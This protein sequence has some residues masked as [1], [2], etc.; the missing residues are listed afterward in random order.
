MPKLQNIKKV[1]V[2][3]SGPIIIGQ[4]AEFDYAGTQACRSLKEE[5]LEVVLV[6]SNPATIMTDVHIAD[7]VYIEPVN[8]EFLESVIKRERPDSLL[9]TLGGQVGLNLAIDLE[10][11]GILREY[12]VQLLGTQIYSIKRAE[13]R[14]LFKETMEKINPDNALTL[15]T[16]DMVLVCGDTKKR[17]PGNTMYTTNSD[18]N[19][20]AVSQTFNGENILTGAIKS[21]VDG[22]TPTVYFLTGHGEKSADD[23]YT[24]FKKNLQNY[25]YAAKSLLLSDVDAVPS[26]AAMVLV[27]APTSDISDSDKD[28]LDAY[29]NEGGNLS[30]LMSPNAGKFNYT[31]LDLIMEEFS[32]IMDYDTV[33]E[34]DASMH[35]SGDDSTI[36]CNLVELSS[37]SEAADL[38]SSLINQGLVPYMTNSRSFYFDTD[39]TGTLTT[40]ELLTTNDT[41]VG[42]PNGGAYDT[43]KITNSEL[44]LAGYSQSNTKNNAKLAVF[45]NADFLDDTHLQDSRYIVAVYLYLSTISWMY[46]TD[47]D[48]G[49]DSKSTVYD[50]ISLPDANSA[51][52]LKPISLVT[53]AEKTHGK[54][55]A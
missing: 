3:G 33:K 25:N 53:F 39:T 24:Q 54:S 1:L 44:M 30:L 5:G 40:A 21:V 31:N 15:N 46:D 37:D 55:A 41:A 2:I 9:A 43:K 8:V 42:E 13:D 23:N 29:L 47:V 4:A 50:E 32:I 49:I 20:N 22:F 16:G 11:K 26:D 28:K 52:S 51:R 10:E 38:T 17:I 36:Q 35:V 45:G 7:R 12:N 27:A 14:E 19:G 34:T 18:D 48:M 6:N